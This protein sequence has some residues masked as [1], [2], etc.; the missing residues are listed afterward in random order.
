MTDKRIG[1][2][3]ADGSIKAMPELSLS[4]NSYDPTQDKRGI[5]PFKFV[6]LDRGMGKDECDILISALL[7][8]AKETPK[9]TSA[10]TL[11]TDE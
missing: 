5:A 8:S 1:T 9:T 4:G 10:R 2:Y 3:N 7:A 11:S 6:I